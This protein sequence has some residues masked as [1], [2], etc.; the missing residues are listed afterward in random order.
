MPRP[1]RSITE[2]IRSR[3]P[4]RILPR[5]PGRHAP[6]GFSNVCFRCAP[7]EQHP[8]QPQPARQGVRAPPQRRPACC[9]QRT[10]KQAHVW[11]MLRQRAN[12]SF[13]SH[14][15][16][17]LLGRQ[18]GEEWLC[19]STGRRLRI[20][21]SSLESRINRALL[22]RVS[23]RPRKQPRSMQGQVRSFKREWTTFGTFTTIARDGRFLPLAMDEP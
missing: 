5:S 10:W 23:R 18:D 6:I 1:S 8:S 22:A 16:G 11:E 2:T 20:E 14:E 21:W 17:T 4:T 15:E 12:R 3:P 9:R 7:G 19:A 13:G